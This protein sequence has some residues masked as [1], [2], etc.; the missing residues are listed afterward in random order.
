MPLNSFCV[1]H[2]QLGWGLPLRVVCV[3]SETPLRK[4]IFPFAS[5]YRL[6]IASGLGWELVPTSLEHPCRNANGSLSEGPSPVF[7]IMIPGK[8]LI[9][10]SLEQ[11]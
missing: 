2:L 11:G 4:T 9:D 7:C 8:H 1:G 10:L 5:G 3:A 6:E